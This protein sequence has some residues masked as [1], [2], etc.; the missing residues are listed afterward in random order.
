[1]SKIIYHGSYSTITEL[2]MDG[3]NEV[4]SI[5]LEDCPNLKTVYITN[6]ANLKNIDICGIEFMIDSV[7]IGIR[8]PNLEDLNIIY[9]KTVI[10]R[11]QPFKQLKTIN[12]SDI[13]KLELKFPCNLA[14]LEDMSISDIHFN[15]KLVFDTHMNSLTD[16]SIIHCFNLNSIVSK[17]N[18]KS[19]RIINIS[20]NNSESI[21]FKNVSP[22][23]KCFYVDGNNIK[24]L[25]VPLPN[26]IN[27]DKCY[28]HITDDLNHP[29]FSDDFF[30]L[31]NFNRIKITNDTEE[32]K[33]E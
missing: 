3:D 9:A 32:I 5:T 24:K 33:L 1:M 30:T 18:T 29:T 6:C 28:I 25:N 17:R 11:R 12:L 31:S 15:G 8:L 19:L 26:K 23:L 21:R 4:E 27:T 7:V 14:K 2:V 13:K 16:L 10:I 22:D 20:D